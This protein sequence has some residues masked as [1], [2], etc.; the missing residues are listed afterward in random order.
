MKLKFKNQT[1]KI[2]IA[3]ITILAF[4]S[5]KQKDFDKEMYGYTDAE[6]IEKP[7]VEKIKNDLIGKKISGWN[8]DGLEEFNTVT[9]TNSRVV[10]ELNLEI[11]VSLDL[12]GSRSGNPYQGYV[13]VSYSRIDRKYDYWEFNKVTGSVSEVITEEDNSQDVSSES[14]N[15]EQPQQ[16][17][18]R[19]Y[20]VCKLC[21]SEIV[22][23]YDLR[24]LYDCDPYY[25]LDYLAPSN[26]VK[27]PFHETCA[28]DYCNGNY[29]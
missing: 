7:S 15:Q 26:Y 13:T 2:F 18:S 20:G 3:F 5:C 12:T 28:H 21:H 29:D 8:F 14:N 23:N 6:S 16:E 10:D 1:R 24:W 17:T 4:S 27:G 11:E 22:S 25:A 19:V 9:I